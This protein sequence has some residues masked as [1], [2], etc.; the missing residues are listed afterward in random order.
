MLAFEVAKKLEPHEVSFLGSFNLP[1]HIKSRMRAL[2]WNM[3]LLHLTHFVGLITEGYAD[4]LEEEGFD[5]LSHDEALAKVFLIGERGRMEELG[6]THCALARWTDIAYGLQSM[7]VNYEPE[8]TVDV[9]EVFHAIPL[10]VAAASR[11]EWLRDH[12][13]KWGDF[14]RTEPKYHEVEGAHYT[15]LGPD[16]VLRFSA[17]LK[18]ALRARGL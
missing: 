9:I 2:T 16:Y 17:T 11:E 1:P 14:C 18:A 3:C 12:L 15:M 13:S 4:T 5:K 8:G 6:L 7:A 10:K